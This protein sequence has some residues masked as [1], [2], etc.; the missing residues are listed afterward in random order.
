[1][2]VWDDPNERYFD[3]GVDRG[4]LYVDDNAVPWNGITGMDEAGTGSKTVLYR[5]G[6][7]YLA[8]V[9]PG[10]F[11]GVLNALFY[12]DAFAACA[13]IP[14]VGSGL[15][16]DNQKPKR[17]GLA[18]RSLVGNGAVDDLFGYQ[19]HL[20]YNAVAAIGT[21]SR[22][23]MTQAPN[24]TEF[25]FDITATPIKLPGLRPSAH[26]IIDTRHL[27]PGVLESLEAILY[28][29][30]RMPVPLELYELLHFGD[31]IIF[32]DLGNGTWKA[33]GSSSNIELTGPGTW[34]I[35]NVNGVDHGDGTYTLSDT[36]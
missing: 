15:F 19:I 9:D 20:V 5:D 14:E 36:P 12:P 31:S 2:L 29:E 33:S 4:V 13:G 30:G 23:T 35:R 34:E 25:T 32:T 18:Y 10:D 21:R 28:E 27:D 11:E 8:D 24:L 16:V 6:R 1:M 22:K 3:H 26:Y 7:I 17:F